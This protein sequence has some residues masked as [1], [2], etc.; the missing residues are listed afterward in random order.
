MTLSMVIVNVWVPLVSA[1]PP[2]SLSVT[3][4]SVLPFALAAGVNVRLPD[5]LMAGPAANSDG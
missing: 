4:T 1:P 5:A 3:S 2:L